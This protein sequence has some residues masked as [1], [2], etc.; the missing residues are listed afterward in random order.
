MKYLLQVITQQAAVI[1][2]RRFGKTY[3]SHLHG[4]KYKIFFTLGV[5]TDIISRNFGKELPPLA[6]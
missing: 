5:G 6:A 3:L 2:Y 4:S 1:P